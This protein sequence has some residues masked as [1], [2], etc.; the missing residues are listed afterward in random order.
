MVEHQTPEQESWVRNLPRRVVSLSK[1]L[2][3]PKVLVIPRKQCLR[4]DMTEKL[5]TGTLYLNKH[6][7]VHRITGT[8]Q[9]TGTHWLLP[10]H[11]I[12]IGFG[13]AIISR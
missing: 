8:H 5:L 1:T 10:E 3:S 7:P 12:N 4:P 9:N 2:Y 6:F 13:H 11:P